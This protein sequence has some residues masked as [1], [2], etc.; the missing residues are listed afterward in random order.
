MRR[1]IGAA[2]AVATALLVVAAPP[3]SAGGPTSVLIVNYDGARA[4]GALTG[5]TTYDALQRALDAMNPPTGDTAAPVGLDEN[6]HIRLV[7]MIHDVTPWRID[8]VTMNGSDIWVNTVMDP[9][10]GVS[11]GRP[12]TWHRPKDAALLRSTLTLLGVIGAAKPGAADTGSSPAPAGPVSQP[13]QRISATD[14]P[15]ESGAGSWWV[16]LVA[17]VLALALGSVLGLLVGPTVRRSLSRSGRT[18]AG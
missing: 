4:S 15:N 8:S 17:V 1:L 2:L 18:R 10:E 9:T 5:S 14:A 11:A 6:R 12:G 16:T 3:A 7:W 13:V